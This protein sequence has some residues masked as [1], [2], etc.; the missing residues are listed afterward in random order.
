M[1]VLSFIVSFQYIYAEGNILLQEALY[2]CRRQY[3]YS[4]GYNYIYV[5]GKVLTLFT[6]KLLFYAGGIIYIYINFYAYC[7]Q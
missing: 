2:R 5:E 7:L 3:I 4:E 6:H 1:L